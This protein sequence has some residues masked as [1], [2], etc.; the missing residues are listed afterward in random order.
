MVYGH[1]VKSL[2]QKMILNGSTEHA[3]VTNANLQLQEVFPLLDPKGVLQV[4]PAAPSMLVDDALWDVFAGWSTRSDLQLPQY[5][6]LITQHC[7]QLGVQ[8]LD[9]SQHL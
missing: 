4:G 3:Y 2:E 8:L 7:A 1:Y 9:G 5:D 6:P